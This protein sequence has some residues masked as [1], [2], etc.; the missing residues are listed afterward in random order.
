MNYKFEISLPDNS[1]FHCEI[2]IDGE[3]TFQ[4]LHDKIVEVLEFD[5]SQIA[6]F[7]TLDR[8][9]NRVKEIALLEMSSDEEETDTWVMDTTMIRE[10]V[11]ASCIE[12]EYVFDFFGN[13]YLKV[14]YAG[15][16]IADSADVLPVC[17]MCN[18]P[19][20]V[21]NPMDDDDK[22][23]FGEDDGEYDDSFMEEF[24]DDYLDDEEEYGKDDYGDDD[25]GGSGGHGGRYESIDDYLD[26]L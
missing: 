10:V 6:S 11:N 7:Y 4:Q 16:Y 12:L 22:W 23:S 25:F 8:M 26:K 13:R 9:G 1:E 18:G 14:E 20:P 15:E 24:S 17:L 5:H 3:Q 2:A 19:L 21:Q